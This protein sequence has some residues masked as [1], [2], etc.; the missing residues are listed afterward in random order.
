M[1]LLSTAIGKMACFLSDRALSKTTTRS[2]RK[3]VV[4]HRERLWILVILTIAALAHGINMFDFPYY[5]GDEGI[6][7]SQAWSVLAEGELAPYTYRYDHAPAGWMQIAAW[8]GLTGGF[9]TFGTAVDSGRVLMLLIQV[10][11][12]FMLYRIARSSSGSMLAATIASLVFALSA[13]GI[14]SHRRVLL[15][16]IATFWMLLSILPLVSG[17]LTLKRVWFSAFALGLSILSKEVTVFLFPIVAYLVFYRAHDSHRWFAAVG[18]SAIASS[19]VSLYFLMATLKG[20]LFPTGTL[21]GGTSEHV[22]LLGTLQL[23]ASRGADG[24]IFNP[25]SLFWRVTQEWA[26]EEPFLVIVGSVA[27]LV[28]VLLATKPHRRLFG[29]IG[30]P[31]LLLWL[32]LGRGGVILEFYLIPLLPLLALNIGILFGSFADWVK[33]SLKKYYRFG[34]AA[35][36]SVQGIVVIVCMA[37]IIMPG[38]FGLQPRMPDDPSIEHP[39]SSIAS[40][41]NP[42]FLWNNDQTNP[43]KQA[44]NWVKDNLSTESKIVTEVGIW[45][46]LHDLPASTSGYKAAHPYWQADLDPLIRDGVFHNN[47][48]NI[49]YIVSSSGFESDVIANNLNLTNS[50]LEHSTP[51]TQFESDGSQIT[52]RR[53]NEVKQLAA[54][55]NP[56]L[57]NTWTWYKDRFVERGRVVDQGMNRR[58]TSEGQ[59]YA[60]LRAVYMDDEEAFDE[61]WGW[62]QKNL[63][64]PGDNSLLAW[65]YGET[66]DGTQGVTDFSTA[67]DADTDAALALL[68]ASKK[69][70]DGRYEEEALRILDD[71]WEEETVS[72]IAGY[73]RVLVAGDWAR[74][75]GTTSRPV[76]NPSYLSP[77]AYKIFAEADPSHDW[78]ALV[79]SS[80]EI[81]QDAQDNPALGGEAGVVP[82][83]LAI[84]P[85]TGATEAAELEGLPTDEF[86]FD[87]T[88]VP[89]RMSL[90]YLWFGDERALEVMEGLNL[91]RR[92]IEDEGRV[93]A[94]YDLG[95]EPTVDYEATSAYAGVLPGLLV[96]GDPAVAHRVF[97][98]KI[99]GEYKNG[100]EGAYWGEDPDNYYNQNM[101][102][103]AT[104][105]MDGSMGNLWAGE[106]V[107]DWE[108]ATAVSSKLAF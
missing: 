1:T 24:G 85:E 17:Q 79:D 11:S 105:V 66:K 39:M 48:R 30:L 108:G 55:A 28:A 71:V 9:Y 98:Q 4:R 14:Y 77:Y 56:V 57:M 102:W 82:N 5:E 23:Q 92:Q 104:A 97:A 2:F 13:Y 42:F 16:N 69:F 91:P 74:G 89:W 96:G 45:T 75:D 94:S 58:T 20:E 50:A 68:F 52:I 34:S 83:W 64:E 93:A 7:M 53:V 47:W 88:R 65:S 18:W 81:L 49:D 84:D 95:G 33:R 29:I 36:T 78:D 40:P 90:D 54:P 15:D 35:G 27:S 21:L 67:T 12:T 99:L 106:R 70:D 25:D 86:S 43:Q 46:D 31:A 37:A 87:A 8:S 22:S 10:A 59:S 63:Q 107:I 100:P 101:A 62:T 72:T 60:M 3:W 6:Y 73:D 51:V 103:F 26:R 41:N 76:V 38:Y 19:V 61:I 80:Y 32:F 44:L